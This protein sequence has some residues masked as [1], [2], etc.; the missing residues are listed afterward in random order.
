MGRLSGLIGEWLKKILVWARRGDPLTL[1]TPA[2]TIQMLT[3]GGGGG[4]F[5]LFRPSHL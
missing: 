5:L 2:A 3:E 4:H 1:T